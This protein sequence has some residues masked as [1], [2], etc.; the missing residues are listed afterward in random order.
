MEFELN[1]PEGVTHLV[2]LGSRAPGGAS[3]DDHRLPTVPFHLRKPFSPDSLQLLVIHGGN[4]A[5]VEFH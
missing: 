3:C 1:C 2:S 4:Q 5:I